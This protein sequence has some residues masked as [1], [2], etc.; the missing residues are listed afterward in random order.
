MATKSLIVES[1]SRKIRIDDLRRLMQQILT[2]F[3][4]SQDD[5]AVVAEPFIEADVRGIYVQGLHHLTHSMV[6]GLRN[7]KL[8]VNGKPRVIKEGPAFVVLDGDRAPGPLSGIAAAD[9]LL[10]K[11]REAGIAAAGVVNGSDMYMIGYYVERLA[12]AGIVGI[13]FVDAPPLMAALG[14]MGKT[15]GTN[16]IAIAVPTDGPNP[17]VLDIS[18]ASFAYWRMHDYAHYGKQLP[19]GIALD[20]DG[21]PTRDA[22]AA[23]KG[24]L[25]PFGG[26]K[27]FGLALCG[28]FLAGNLLGCDVG[29]ALSSW[30]DEGPG[31]A[32][33]QGHLFIGVD[34]AA[35]GDPGVFRRAVSNYI[36]EIKT[37]Q[38]APGINEIRIP[39]EASFAARERNLRAG[40]ITIDDVVWNRTSR[41]AEELGVPM[42]QTYG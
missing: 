27:G 31:T 26:H 34:P 25:L 28:A 38:K 8:N 21:N 33:N 22:A 20:Q 35:F 42:P 1:S 14:G 39:G 30:R 29:A 17:F 6:R 4:L 10:R 11:A 41:I 18:T 23:L 15:I 13:A 5:A 36:A 7:K 37:S 19:D 3:G 40:L 2:G 9:I 32:G 16:P 12:R 24:V